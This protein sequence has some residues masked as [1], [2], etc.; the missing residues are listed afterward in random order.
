VRIVLIVLVLLWPASIFAQTADGYLKPYQPNAYGPGINSDATGRPFSW[1][2]VPGN[3]P[4]DPLSRVRPDAYGPGIGMDQYG[5]PVQP[6]PLSPGDDPDVYLP[7]P[8]S[9]G[10]N[11][12]AI[13]FSTGSGAIGYSYNYRSGNDAQ[14]SALQSCGNDCKVVVRFTNACGALAVG[15]DRR[16]GTGW[17]GNRQE[18]ESTAMGYCSSSTTGCGIARWVCTTR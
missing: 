6:V 15:T 5:R 3:G 11:F 18:A 16:Y 2:P 9:P 8:G 12:G 1:Q 7:Q 17:A 14:E 4:V 10:D 13:A